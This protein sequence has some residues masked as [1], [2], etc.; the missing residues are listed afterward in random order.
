MVNKLWALE[1]IQCMET[2]L[3]HIYIQPFIKINFICYLNP[4]HLVQSLPLLWTIRPCTL[5]LLLS[6][7]FFLSSHLLF[8]IIF[9]SVADPFHFD[10]R[11]SLVGSG[12]DLKSRK[13]LLFWKLFFHKKYIVPKND[14][15]VPF[16]LIVIVK[17]IHTDPDPDPQHCLLPNIIC[18]LIKQSSLN[19]S[20]T[21][22]YYHY[23]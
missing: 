22:I 2:T 18:S 20:N 7:F 19:F 17:G 10:P 5:H 16:A 21:V 6:Y 4:I 1:K 8:L 23:A 14:F 13:N 9:P 3:N 15:C 12:S 11:I